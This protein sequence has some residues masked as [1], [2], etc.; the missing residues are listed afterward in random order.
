MKKPR[1]QKSFQIAEHIDP[2]KKVRVYRNLHRDCYSVKQG[3]IVRCHA[4]M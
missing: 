4:E 1:V 2:T 3:G